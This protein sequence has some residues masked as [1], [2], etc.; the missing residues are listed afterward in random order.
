MSETFA[1]FRTMTLKLRMIPIIIQV[2]EEM[3][4]EVHLNGDKAMT[5]DS[6]SLLVIDCDNVLFAVGADDWDAI[7]LLACMSDD[8]SKW[9]DVEHIWPRYR[10]E[11]C[12]E[13]IDSLSFSTCCIDEATL[14]L[15]S[16]QPWV[17]FDLVQK[18]VFSGGGYDELSS[19]ENYGQED[20]GKRICI[21]IRLPTWWEFVNDASPHHVQQSRVDSPTIPDARRDILWGEAWRASLARQMFEVVGSDAWRAAD[22]DRNERGLYKMTVAVHRDWLMTPR[23]DLDGRM[24]RE[25]L[26]DGRNWIDSLIDVR[27]FGGMNDQMSVPLSD[28]TTSYARSPMGIVEVVTYFDGTRALIEKGWEWI[29]DNRGRVDVGEGIDELIEV[30]ASYQRTWLESVG[31][32]PESPA[33][34]ILSERQ[35]IPLVSNEGSHI[36]DCE[37]P[38]CLTMSGGGFGPS[39]VMFDGHHLDLDDDFAFSLCDDFEDWKDQQADFRGFSDSLDSDVNEPTAMLASS[40]SLDGFESVWK[41][42]YVNWEMMRGTPMEQMALSF[43]LADMVGTLQDADQSSDIKKL[44]DAFAVYRTQFI[45]DKARATFRFKSVLDELAERHVSLVTRTA[46]FQSKLD[47][48]CRRP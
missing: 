13:L 42:S 24:P 12:S 40:T 3:F 37:C 4:F 20:E 10:T 16:T 35:R 33:D 27:R 21:P 43:L 41:N 39:F 45:A 1:Y 38:I 2:N 5:T 11:L 14:R 36:I 26:H 25:C 46:D 34:C 31:D 44:N 47:E 23:D 18:R 32:E 48:L 28:E 15:D 9:S 29:A 17:A 8:P 30:L 7:T 6:V 22:A 19:D